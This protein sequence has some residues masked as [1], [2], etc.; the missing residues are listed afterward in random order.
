MSKLNVDQQTVRE[1]LGNRKNSFL[2]P[3]Y[4]RP[5]AWTEEQCQTLWDDIYNFA[6]PNEDKDAFNDNEEYFLG[7]IVTFKNDQGQLEIIDGQQRLTTL[8]LMFRAF[9]NAFQVA[10]DANSRKTKAY[11]EQCIWK[12]D[13][14]D[15]IKAE[16]L[17]INSEVATDKDKE[18]FLRIL[19]TGMVDRSSRSQYAQNYRFFISKVD[20]F[21]DVNPMSFVYLP[22]RILNNCIL[23]PIEAESQD[24]ALRIFSTLND[25]GLPLSDADI[26]KAQFYKFYGDRGEKDSFIEQWKRLESMAND[27]FKPSTGTPMDDLFA[28]YMYYLRAKEGNKSTTTESLRRFYAKNKFAY[29]HNETTVLNL[30]LLVEFWSDVANQN[31]TRFTP[32]VIKQLYILNDAPNGMWEYLLSVY[33]LANKDNDNKLN[34]ASLYDFLRQT[35][36]F[37]WGYALQRP[38]VNALRTPVY[39]E[40]V[41]IVNGKFNNFNEYKFNA[42]QIRSIIN[43]FEFTNQRAITRSML[44]WYAFTLD[45]Q[46]VPS[47]TEKFDIE[48]IYPRKRQQIEHGLSD[49][50]IID[51]LGNKILLE[52]SINIKASD[53]RFKDKKKFYMGE[54][55]RGKDIRPSRIAE[56]AD[57]VK[58][59]D[60]GESEIIERNNRIVNKFIE[61]LNTQNLLA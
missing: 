43:N 22:Q 42:E 46:V 50:K 20:R 18:E 23:L 17:K 52:K 39:A 41:N 34:N 30:K 3:D 31:S 1:L 35:T 15:N 54:M 7:S 57:L 6:L 14:F 9:Y 2:I 8:L 58:L 11:I 40:M 51:K 13:E 10:Q 56:I 24:T 28:R 61:L 32:E 55:R 12:T 4:Q 5:Y 60:F 53:Y 33:F 25:R 59:D 45:D 29:L 44:T 38:G 19:K 21:K 49:N 48:H 16:E 47:L 27:I 37:V 26:F 36:A